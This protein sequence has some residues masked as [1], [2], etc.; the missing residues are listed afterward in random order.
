MA[1][2]NLARLLLIILMLIMSYTINGDPND[3]DL[4]F[5]RSD[6]NRRKNALAIRIHT[7]T[8]IYNNCW[9]V[10]MTLVTM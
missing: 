1:H 2:I 3:I 5:I 9:L 7:R 8:H 10:V 6:S 4:R